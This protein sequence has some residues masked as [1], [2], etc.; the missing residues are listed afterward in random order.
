MKM[1]PRRDD[2]RLWEQLAHTVA[3]LHT[4]TTAERFGRHRLGRLGRLGRLRQ[5][6]TWD[7]D[8]HA[9]LAERRMTAGGTMDL[10][11]LRELLSVIAHDDDWGAVEAVRKIIAPF[12]RPGGPAMG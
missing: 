3:A 8:G 12:R 1:R 5:D 4:F 7:S 11:H 10:F 9:F 2:E 6:N